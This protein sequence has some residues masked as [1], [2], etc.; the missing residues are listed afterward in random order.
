MSTKS[1]WIFALVALAAV[2]LLMVLLYLPLLRHPAT[3]HAAVTS[4]LAVVS[5][6]LLVA[7]LLVLGLLC[8]Y[9]KRCTDR[10]HTPL[11]KFFSDEGGTA[12][13]EFL[14]GMPFIMMILLLL[15]QSALLF[16]A[17]MV[18]HYAG[19]AATRCAITTVQTNILAST[20]PSDPPDDSGPYAG[21]AN[22][23]VNNNFPPNMQPN[24]SPPLP[25]SL[26]MTRIHRAAAIALT[27]I[28][29]E[30][31][32]SECEGADGDWDIPDVRALPDTLANGITSAIQSAG[33]SDPNQ[34]W[35]KHVAAQY[36]YAWANSTV[37]LAQPQHWQGGNA[38]AACPYAGRQHNN[39]WDAA[40]DSMG[41]GANN[42]YYCP[43]YNWEST[44]SALILD[45]AWNEPLTV[46]LTYFI[47]L[48]IPYAS[49]ALS[50]LGIGEPYTMPDSG[51]NSYKVLVTVVTQL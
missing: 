51:E 20:D 42:G 43:Y 16:N 40:T 48:E 4:P 18:V 44:A 35:P 24:V 2:C 3:L 28:S 46:T 31:P 9:L 29:D 21:E 45:Y 12:A 5:M 38:N 11:H 17:N 8:L 34:P 33:S 49:A 13:F 30:Y 26:K 25:L 19:F 6:S 22:Y 23:M 39:T 50:K 10:P 1:K 32:T 27:P 41:W 14:L 7:C 36:S 15:L 37:T 47:P